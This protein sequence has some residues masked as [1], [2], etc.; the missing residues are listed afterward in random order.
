MNTLLKDDSTIAAISTPVGQGGIG[1][2]KISGKNAM[3]IVESIFRRAVSNKH[4]MGKIKKRQLESH[5]LYLGNI[6]NPEDGNVV[7]EVLLTYMKAPKSYTMEDVVE[8]NAHSGLVVLNAIL[9]LVLKN[10]ARLAEPGEFTKRAFLNGRID[11]TQAEAVAEIIQSKTE[12]ALDI[13]V[14]QAGG[15]F[16]RRIKSIRNSLEEILISL[17]AAIDFPEDIEVNIDNDSLIALVEQDVVTKINELIKYYN[18]GFII[19]DGLRLAI[20][21]KPNVGKSSLLNC[22]SRKDRAIVTPIPGTTRDVIEEVIDLDG[23]PVTI[24]DTAGLHKTADPVEIIGMDKAW[25]NIGISDIVLFMIDASIDI[26]ADDKHIF[27]R[28]NT[29]KVILVIN[30]SDLVDIAFF[31]DIPKEWNELPKIKISALYENGITELRGLIKSVSVGMN[32]LAESAL[33]PNMRQK[34]ALENG[35]KAATQAIDGLKNDLPAEMISMDIRE[36]MDNLD[37]V[38]GINLRQDILGEIFK[39][40]CIGK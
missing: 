39:R 30:K 23:I 37:E 38:L 25:D 27:E 29:K 5:K 33:I 22:L 9:E 36:A 20:T 35:L 15:Y 32:D 31:P 4:E 34:C 16:G 7:D 19:R 3:N 12:K 26:D 1:I 14:S 10:G 28:I 24:S 6:I 17:E 11:L 21:G 8:I 40:F 18:E 13:A 2:V